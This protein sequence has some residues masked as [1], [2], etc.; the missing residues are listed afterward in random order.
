MNAIMLRQYRS[1]LI[2]WRE[3]ETRIC[4][5]EKELN[6]IQ[7]DYQS[8]SDVVTKGKR[9]KKPLGLCVIHGI[10]DPAL[11]RKRAK[12]RERKARHEIQQAKLE[13]IILDVEEYINNVE[14]SEARRMMRY[15]FVDGLDSWN[16]T[17]KAMG[18]GYS[19]EACKKKIQRIL[20]KK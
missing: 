9:G 12:L 7:P 14:D 15:F 4:S 17:A 20:Q 3:E 19:G 5:M 1:M 16:E 8:V 10:E 2:E 18:E 11:A 6:H 13:N